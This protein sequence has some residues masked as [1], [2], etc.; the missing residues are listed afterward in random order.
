MEKLNAIEAI[1][2]KAHAE[3]RSALLETEV[4]AI[5]G[6]AGLA[7]PKHALYP[8]KD[9]DAPAAALDAVSR[10]EGPKVVVKVVSSKTLH[11]TEAGGVKVAVREKD[12]VA[13]IFK[14]MAARFP[15]AEGLM[16]CEF[17]EHSQFALG[18]EIMVGARADD[19]KHVRTKVEQDG[20]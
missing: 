6:L 5:L 17:A 20:E 10:F 12:G 8:L 14:D 19:A 18:E 1:L 13:E 11:K 7:A 4:Y 9:L 2:E 16:A 15:E 3:K